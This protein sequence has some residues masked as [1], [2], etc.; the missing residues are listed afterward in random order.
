MKQETGLGLAV[1]PSRWG[2]RQS[3]SEIWDSERGGI[4]SGQG[5]CEHRVPKHP[6]PERGR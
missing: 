1:A 6:N 2:S 5:Q 4:V 3:R